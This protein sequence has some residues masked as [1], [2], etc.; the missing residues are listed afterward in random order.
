MPSLEGKNV[1]SPVEPVDCESRE[2]IRRMLREESL[3]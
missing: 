2:D 1:G 3:G